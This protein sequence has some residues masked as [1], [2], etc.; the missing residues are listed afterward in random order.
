MSISPLNRSSAPQ[1]IRLC[2]VCF[3]QGV[4]GAY[5]MG[6]DYAVQEFVDSHESSWTYGVLGEPDDYD[7]KMWR[8]SLYRWCRNSGLVK[9]AE[10]Y[11]YE[12]KKY[13]HLFCPIIFSMRFYLLGIREWLAYPNPVGIERFRKNSNVHWDP[14]I[15]KKITRTEVLADIQDMAYKYRRLPESAKTV[16]D[17]TIVDFSAALFALTSPVSTVRRIYIDGTK[18]KNAKAKP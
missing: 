3:K 17:A 18:I 13:D 6:D 7:W 14:K 2:S 10:D 11:L 4:L 15:A 9:F 16:P 5:D 8:F 1:I 12:V